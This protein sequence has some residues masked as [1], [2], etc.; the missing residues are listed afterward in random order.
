MLQIDDVAHDRE[1]AIGPNPEGLERAAGRCG[2]VSRS[3]GTAALLPGSWRRVILLPLLLT[4]LPQQPPVP[5]PGWG[6]DPHSPNG[7]FSFGMGLA[8]IGD[9]DGDHLDD[10]T[11]SDPE[12]SVPATIWIVSSRNGAVIE[13]LCSDDDSRCFGHSIAA[14]RDGIGEILVGLAPDWNETAPGRAAIYSGRTRALLRT[15]DAPAGVRG[16]GATVQGLRDVDGDDAGDVLVT[17][18]PCNTEGFAFVYAGRT[19]RLL[20]RIQ[21]PPGV[22]A[23]G[24]DP[25]G[26]VDADGIADLAFAGLI[27]A[28]QSPLLRLHSGC[29]GHLIAEVDTQITSHGIGLRTLAIEDQDRDGIPDLLFCTRGVLQLRSSADLRLLRSFDTP[30]LRATD[31]VRGVARVGD[32]D[33]DGV[34]DIVLGNPDAGISGGVAALSGSDG[35]VLWKLDAPCTWRNVDL[36]EAGQSVIAIRDLDKDGVREFLWAPD[37]RD[38]GGPGLVFVSSGKDGHLLRVFMRGPGLTVQCVGPKG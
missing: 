28:A 35:K 14:L 29:D 3:R 22:E 25:I 31:S 10:F 21:S 33:K 12:G 34:Q 36:Y 8:D 4:F 30:D 9:V 6:V 38:G 7:Y 26:D 2:A 20:Y 23:R 27:T 32:I 1:R 13:T 17:G 11:I 15:L 19:G 37:N 16:F 24:V 18:S 5:N